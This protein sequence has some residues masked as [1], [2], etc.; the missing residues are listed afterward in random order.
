MT[1]IKGYSK[2]FLKMNTPDN[3]KENKQETS[4]RV[5]DLYKG[6]MWTSPQVFYIILSVEILNN[7]LI[8]V[9]WFRSILR[10]KKW[11]TDSSIFDPKSV[12]VIL[13]Q[14]NIISPIKNQ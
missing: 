3:K 10:T 1:L 12:F 8:S 2:V 9:S 5:G 14:Q 7:D 11:E 4:L 13:G 6:F